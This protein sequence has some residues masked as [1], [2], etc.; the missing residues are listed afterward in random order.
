MLLYI[1][2]FNVQTE[3][4]VQSVFRNVLCIMINKHVNIFRILPKHGHY[5]NT[6]LCWNT[7]NP[8]HT[9]AGKI[10]I[11]LYFSSVGSKIFYYVSHDQN[12][13][14]QTNSGLC[15][16]VTY[17]T[18][19][20]LSNAMYINVTHIYD[21]VMFLKQVVAVKTFLLLI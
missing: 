6:F 12:N 3:R 10:Y 13:N 16:S 1:K 7:S 9:C 5:R 2:G 15:L 14:K 18:I 20:C 17:L 19:C 4:F 8:P 11:L 21:W